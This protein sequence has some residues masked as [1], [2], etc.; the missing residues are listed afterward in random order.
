MALREWKEEHMDTHITM[1]ELPQSEQPVEKCARYGAQALSDAELL[2]VI[3]RSGTKDM[4]AL[5]LSQ[6]LLARK[7]RSLLNLIVMDLDEMREIPGIGLVKAVQLKCVAELSRRI[8]K[9]RRAGRVT[10]D[11]PDSVASYYMESMRHEQKEK[12]LLAM[13]NG[14]SHLLGEEVVSVGTVNASLVSSR[15]IFIKALA[16]GAVQIVLLHNHPS[17]DPRPSAE[18]IRVTKAVA[19]AG[20]L[21]GISLADHIIIGDNRYV[22]FRE[23]GLLG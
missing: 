21:I 20:D 22:S 11:N 1:K 16:Y 4:T 6:L 12:L 19:S 17:G 23:E 14:K 7:E 9:T 2:A 15:E 13:F 3:L 10:L 18:D 8:A 5:Q